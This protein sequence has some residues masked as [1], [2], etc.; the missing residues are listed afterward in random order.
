LSR[1]FRS[2]SSS[3]PP[4]PA[5]GPQQIERIEILG[6]SPAHEIV[7]PRAAVRAQIDDLA[8]EDELAMERLADGGAELRE[9]RELVVVA[10]NEASPIV[11]YMRERAEAVVLQLED[12]AGVIERFVQNDWRHRGE[13]KRRAHGFR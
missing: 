4:I 7:K 13:A 9:R 12:K 2:I 8:I 11:L 10:E 5:I 1:R 3:P 6:R